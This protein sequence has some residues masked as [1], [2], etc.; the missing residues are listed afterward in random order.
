[1]NDSNES[2]PLEPWT[3]FIILRSHTHSCEVS[4]KAIILER[5][6]D[7]A[8]KVCFIDFQEKVIPPCKKTNPVC[9]LAL[10]KSDKYPASQYLTMVLFD[11]SNR[12]N[13]D[14]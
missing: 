7:I 12:T 8:T 10:W 5:F 11:F 9:D 14:L 2:I 3:K 6:L 1:V 4:Q 13:Q